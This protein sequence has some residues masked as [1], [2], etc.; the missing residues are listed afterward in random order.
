MRV[1]NKEI[2]L[3]QASTIELKIEAPMLSV[4]LLIAID[5][6]GKI[7]PEHFLNLIDEVGKIS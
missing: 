4:K 5:F 3:D 6:G 1:I 7:L 2:Y